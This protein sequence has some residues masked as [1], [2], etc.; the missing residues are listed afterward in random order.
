MNTQEKLNAL[1]N[2]YTITNFL[3]VEQQK[4]VFK[5]DIN[6]DI[7]N[8]LLDIQAN[9]C[10]G[11]EPSCQI[12]SEACD[13]ISEKTLSQDTT[14]RDSLYY[15]YLG[16]YADADSCANVYTSTQLSYLNPNNESE[17]SDLMQDKSITSI[18]Q[19]CLAWHTQKVAQACEALKSYI[20]QD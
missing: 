12:V 18:A 10:V 7:K 2:A 14:D 13:I 6:E 15:E 5:D 9:L 4:I 3:N 1:K 20:L 19:A 8:K 16:F 17:I 11:F